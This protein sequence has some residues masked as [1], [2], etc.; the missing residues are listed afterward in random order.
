MINPYAYFDCLAISTRLQKV[1]ESVAEAEVHLFTY[2]ACLLSLYKKHPASDWEY[3][4]ASTKT[5]SPFSPALAEAVPEL[6]MS[7]LLRRTNNNYLQITTEGRAEYE[8]LR[9]L[10]QNAGREIFLEGASSSVLALP[11]GIVREAILHEPE[12][13]RATTV[14]S[15]RALLD[16]PGVGIL[17]DQFSVLSAAVGVEVQSLMVPSVVWLTYLARFSKTLEP[18]FPDTIQ[19]QG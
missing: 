13:Q 3:S 19:L 10:S 18:A 1:F 11:V 4:Y 2:L 12:L 9:T 17:Y 15:T 5:G 6:V 14:S 16:G 7:G 8:F